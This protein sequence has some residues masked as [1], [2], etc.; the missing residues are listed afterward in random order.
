MKWEE[1]MLDAASGKGDEDASWAQTRGCCYE[2][3]LQ[4]YLT[5][6]QDTPTD[7][8]QLFGMHTPRVRYTVPPTV[9]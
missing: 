9:V 6:V 4:S 1:E 7:R 3:G 8:R 2:R 5:G